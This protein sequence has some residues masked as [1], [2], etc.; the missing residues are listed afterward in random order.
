MAFIGLLL[1]LAAAL[2]VA[3]V[4]LM[5]LL[6]VVH[7]RQA[8]PVAT[9]F[10]PISVLKPLCGAEDA[11]A[12]NLASFVAL[13]YP[14][15]YEVLLGVRSPEDAAYPVACEAVRRWPGR[16][17]LVLQRGAV[18][19]N[20][21]VNQLVCLASAARYDILVVSDSNIRVPQ[22]YLLDI[23][24]HLGRPGVGCV[25]HPLAG[26]GHR[27]LGALLDNLHLGGTIAPGMVC[28]QRVLKKALVVGKSMA[29]WR[30]DLELLGGFAS[31]AN[32]LAEDHV[33][34]NRLVTPAGGGRR[35]T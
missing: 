18:G 31:V 13:P 4:A 8:A 10:P 32:V 29:L 7:L 30:R 16:V 25:T 28:A 15:A 22:G 34:G 17:R 11:L 21:K 14:G 27:S 24:G 23:A 2:G 9:V 35:R 1:L 19:F 6:T 33:L 5:L 20:P 26:N 3:M 12:E